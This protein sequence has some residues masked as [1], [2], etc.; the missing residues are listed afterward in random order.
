MILARAAL[1]P[2][3]NAAVT[4]W[5]VKSPFVPSRLRRNTE[6]RPE[7]HRAW[8]NPRKRNPPFIWLDARCGSRGEK[9]TKEKIT[10][11]AA[12]TNTKAN[13]A[14]MHRDG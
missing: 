3:R 11:H 5:Y 4:N 12:A 2:R 14:A 1:D 9:T 8:K 7:S 6:V 10:N 13:S